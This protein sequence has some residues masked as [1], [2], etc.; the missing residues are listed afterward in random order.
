MQ[1]KQNY[2]CKEL[3]QAMGE[4][5]SVYLSDKH[6]DLGWTLRIHHLSFISVTMVK[7]VSKSKWKR[8]RLFGLHFEVT[9]HH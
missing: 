3:Q 1:K 7:P 2:A 9:V 4:G 5:C 6:G 8:S